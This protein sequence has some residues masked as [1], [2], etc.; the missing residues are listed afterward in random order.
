MS[1]QAAALDDAVRMASANPARMLGMDGIGEVKVGDRA[2]LNRFDGAAAGR[3]IPARR[4]CGQGERLTGAVVTQRLSGLDLAVVATYLIG[5]TLFGLRFRGAKDKSLR[6]YFLAGQTIPWW[7]IA[8]SIVS[9][10]DEH[11]DDY[12]DP[13]CG[14]CGGH[15]IFAGGVWVHDRA[16]WWWRCSFC[17]SIF[18][19]RC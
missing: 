19:A 14:I 17:R 1:L 8:L 11:A 10:G 13:W 16:A 18:R 12:L 7:A 6:G 15:R 5:I 3:D 9:C 4:G 2:D